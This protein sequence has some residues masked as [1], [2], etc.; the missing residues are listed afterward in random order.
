MS[1][2]TFND[3]YVV[4]VVVSCI[5][6]RHGITEE[7]LGLPKGT[8][9]PHDVASL[10]N[11][12]TVTPDELRAFN[13]LRARARRVLDTGVSVGLGACFTGQQLPE[14]LDQL[15]KIEEEYLSLRSDFISRY[16]EIVEAHAATHPKYGHLIRARAPSLTYVE[17]Q[18]G[19][20]TDVMK[21]AIGSD[22][23]NEG[24]LLETLKRPENDIGARL[25]WE[26]AEFTRSVYD[27]SIKDVT[28]VSKRSLGSLRDTLLPKLKSFAVLDSRTRPVAALLEGL[29]NETDRQLA[30]IPRG[31]EKGLTGPAFDRFMTQFRVLMSV[32]LM[33]AHAAAHPHVALAPVTAPRPVPSPVPET[34]PLFGPAP[35]RPEPAVAPAAPLTRR[36][37]NW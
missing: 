1:K 3:V 18:I 32:E 17:G 23:P 27:R 8:L 4:N 36:A 6:G 10:G 7:D 35:R 12:I 26:T 30:S 37:I 9:P 15:K 33:E 11:L 19:F 2:V 29:L 31:Q 21:L 34:R 16:A 25:L 13:T 14:K 22:D 24:V 28:A 20:R 5:G